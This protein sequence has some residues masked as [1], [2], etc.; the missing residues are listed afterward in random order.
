MVFYIVSVCLVGLFPSH[1]RVVLLCHLERLDLTLYI[2]LY[3]CLVSCFDG[4]PTAPVQTCDRDLVARRVA[5]EACPR[6]TYVSPNIELLRLCCIADLEFARVHTL[7]DPEIGDDLLHTA[8]D[9][10]TGMIATP[11]EVLA[12]K[13]LISVGHPQKVFNISSIHNL[14][15]ERWRQLL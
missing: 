9:L 12:I 5:A 4:K 8:T 15:G 7:V 3:G 14:R 11:R 1:P 6:K 10:A 13:M 2:A